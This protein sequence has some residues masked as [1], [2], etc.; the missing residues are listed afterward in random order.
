[1]PFPDRP[2][3]TGIRTSRM[4]PAGPV[5]IVA[6]ALIVF[7]IFWATTTPLVAVI[8]ALTALAAGAFLLALVFRTG[9]HRD[10]SRAP[11]LWRYR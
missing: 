2:R 7:T 11:Q 10:G 4:S 6:V 3:R 9:G 5:S 1:M 8:T